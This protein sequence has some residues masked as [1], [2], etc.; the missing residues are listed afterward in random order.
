MS[1]V[2]IMPGPNGF[3]IRTFECARCDYVKAIS[4]EHDPMKSA[5]AGWQHSHLWP[6]E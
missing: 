1:L 2:R 6:P 4:I 5:G 3:D